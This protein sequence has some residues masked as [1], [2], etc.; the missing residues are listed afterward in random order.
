MNKFGLTERD[1]DV[2]QNVLKN[3]PEIKSVL[4]FGSR[5]KGT[6]QK[7][8]DIDICIKGENITC[9]TTTKAHYQLEEE[10]NLPYFF[11][12]VNYNTITNPDMKA[13]IDRVGKTIY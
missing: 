7:G 9:E 1:I 5:A 10:T 4:V 3:F 11:D 8:S 12:I 2:I 13:H 6:A